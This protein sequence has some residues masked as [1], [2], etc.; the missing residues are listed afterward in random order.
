MA[1]DSYVEISCYCFNSYTTH[2]VDMQADSVALF[3]VVGPQYQ[4]SYISQPVKAM[5]EKVL[6]TYLPVHTINSYCCSSSAPGYDS[7]SVEVYRTKAN[8][9]DITVLDTFF[10]VGDYNYLK[11]SQYDDTGYVPIDTLRIIDSLPDDSISEFGVHFIDTVLR[12]RDSAGAVNGVRVGA[13]TFVFADT[14]IAYSIFPDIFVGDDTVNVIHTKYICTYYD[15]LIGSESDSSR[16]LYIQWAASDSGYTIGLPPIPEYM[17][18]YTRKLY[19][20]FQFV[21][22]DTLQSADSLYD[23][24]LIVDNRE[25]RGPSTTYSGISS[26]NGDYYFLLKLM[27]SNRL[28]ECKPPF[29]QYSGPR[30]LSGPIEYRVKYTNALLPDY[31]TI[32]TP[33]LCI[34]E[35][36]GS[37]S[38]YTDTISFDSMLRGSIYWRSGAPVKLNYITAFDDKLWGAVGAYVYWSYLDSGSYWGAFRN[39]AL[40]PDD[41]DEITAIAPF[42]EYV[43]VYKNHSQFV[44]TPATDGGYTRNWV[45]E[46]I[47]C[48]APHSIKS[49]NNTV[50]YLSEYGVVS[51]GAG[52]Y[53]ERASD[54]GIISIP[55]NDILLNR[56]VTELRKMTAAPIVDQKY[57]LTL[58]DK[59]ATFVYD[60][61]TGGWSIWTY[62]FFQATSFDTVKYAHNI[63]AQDLL[64][65]KKTT[66]FI[67]K[68]DTTYADNGTAY[69]S[70]WKSAPINISSELYR[71]SHLGIW[72]W[73]K[74][75]HLR[76]YNED[77]DSAGYKLTDTT[78]HYDIYGLSPNQSGY[79][80]VDVRDNTTADSLRIEAIDIW[81]DTPTERTRR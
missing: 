41:G 26:L 13:P 55:I 10:M 74:G 67:Y 80:Q 57:R 78:G 36:E 44:L 68:A 49:Y 66:E 62:S 61:V 23:T 52:Q 73:G 72:R 64:F 35:I 46:G 14:A 2:D 40:N 43:K 29:Q 3:S 9:G 31:D 1:N 6:L 77:G 47:G 17:P 53:L 79:F 5:G 33:F 37:D 34:A 20:S 18:Y 45:V 4:E 51:E 63:P 28:I 42:R 25:E 15:T 38:A 27:N 50:I 54:A 56:N 75:L 19:R 76:L 12:G 21:N 71:L 60:L 81:I 39:I 32:T 48:V 30:K 22:V 59:D 8:P 11:I 16:S 24:V 70:E 58:P 69:Q 65:T 7:I